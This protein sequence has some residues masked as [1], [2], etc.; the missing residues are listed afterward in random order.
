MRRQEW[1]SK[2]RSW[3][4]NSLDR[5]RTEFFDTRVSGHSEIWQTLK[6]ALE[7]L[8]EADIAHQPTPTSLD[9]TETEADSDEHNPAV[10]LATAQSIL[11]AA[12][13]TLPTGNLA[14]GVYDALGNYYQLPAQVVSDP[15]NIVSGDG[16]GDDNTKDDLPVAEDT[17]G[18]VDPGLHDTQRRREDKGKG[19]IDARTQV[20][21]VVRLSETSRDLKLHVGKDE[22]VRCI[23]RRILEETGVSSSQ[24]PF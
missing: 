8:W 24:H 6:A 20:L 13:I 7:V 2:D 12:D 23:I 11:D 19:V 17:S 9:G 1:A 14:D 21:A 16:V 22:N 10:A 4:R 15:V 5:E 3:S 18:N